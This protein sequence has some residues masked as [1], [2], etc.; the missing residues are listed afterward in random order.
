MGREAGEGGDLTNPFARALE[1]IAR[2]AALGKMKCKSCG[3]R[4][5]ERDPS[6][7][8]QR[9][10]CERC[11]GTLPIG[12]RDGKWTV[13]GAP[14]RGR[15]CVKYPCVCDCGTRSIVE[16]GGGSG[17]VLHTAMCKGCMVQAPIGL[18]VGT[19]VVIERGQGRHSLVWRCDCGA[20]TRNQLATARVTQCR[21][22]LAAP[23]LD[24]IPVTRD[25]LTAIASV[26]G[27][28]RDTIRKRL[29]P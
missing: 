7:K 20:L 10:T 2:T 11:R 25:V 24:G 28:K 15:G 22:C 16:K 9:R 12:F 29:A 26:L 6:A 3:V 8:R 27:S 19:R 14:I 18:R 5:V 4:N 17:R 23:R 1:R 21:K 13:D